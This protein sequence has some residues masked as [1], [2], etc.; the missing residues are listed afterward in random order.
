IL[1]AP[2]G[3]IF[4]TNG[5]APTVLI[6]DL[7]I[8]G[9]NGNDINGATSGTSAAIT[10]RTTNQ[11]TFTVTSASK[12]GE[13]NSLTWQN[14]RVRPIASSPLTNGNI[15]KS[16]TSTSVMTA[17][18]NSTTSFGSL[19]EVGAS[20]RLGIQTQPSTNATAGRTFVQQPVIR[21]EDASG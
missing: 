5:S 11:I 20:T 7:T 18:T 17:V 12:G 9:N 15:S 14:V 4:D 19:I 2:A 3:F 1:N 21:V 6:T 10:S 16:G 8:G 13:T